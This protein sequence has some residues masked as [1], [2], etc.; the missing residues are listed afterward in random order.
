MNNRNEYNSKINHSLSVN[1]NNCY[2]ATSN[3]NYNTLSQFNNNNNSNSNNKCD[4][5][6]YQ[7]CYNNECH[8]QNNNDNNNNN[9]H[10]NNNYCNASCQNNNN[11]IVNVNDVYSCCYQSKSNETSY[12]NSNNNNPN[13]PNNNTMNTNNNNNNNIN[14]VNNNN[15]NINNNIN[16]N[17]NNAN[18]YKM[19]YQNSNNNNTSI[20]QNNNSNNNEK[21][22][23]KP[24]SGWL[25]TLNF[26]YNKNTVK[27]EPKETI[28]KPIKNS[29][30]SSLKALDSTSKF[31]NNYMIEDID[32]CLD[33]C[34]STFGNKNKIKSEPLEK[35]DNDIEIL[36]NKN[37]KQNS[38]LMNGLNKFNMKAL[39]SSFEKIA[40]V[41]EEENKEKL[42]LFIKK[43]ENLLKESLYN[44]FNSIPD[45]NVNIK[46]ECDFDDKQL[47]KNNLPFLQ[48]PP[49]KLETNDLLKLSPINTNPPFLNDLNKS[50]N[51]MSFS[52]LYNSNSNSSNNT[53]ELPSSLK[54]NRKGKHM[55]KVDE[56]LA[57]NGYQIDLNAIKDEDDIEEA[58]KKIEE[59]IKV[60]VKDETSSKKMKKSSELDEDIVVLEKRRKNTEA[61][62]RSR[63]RKVL[64]IMNLEKKVKALEEKN[65]QLSLFVAKQQQEKEIFQQNYSNILNN[66]YLLQKKMEK[67]K[68]ILNENKY[69]LPPDVIEKLNL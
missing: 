53:N 60:E 44:D 15:N 39:N 25:S 67:T 51:S 43:E 20:N 54:L 65:S 33:I 11:S 63:M 45:F 10:Y 49:F 27:Q 50:C 59:S 3:M 66:Y 42:K 7:N 58:I 9:C 68:E 24:K 55:M 69:R 30:S 36:Y 29:E 48:L 32:K 40:K 37:I 57:K 2:N 34:E 47:L 64:K 28:K 1:G 16:N 4:N 23:E 61:A 17:N 26:N 8:Y 46:K 14:S 35:K 18:N 56:L 13:N 62:R 19:T 41:K 12:N 6:V 22:D 5:V 38:Q 31:M 21:N 52:S